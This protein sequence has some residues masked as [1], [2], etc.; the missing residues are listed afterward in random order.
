MANGFVFGKGGTPSGG[1]YS[2]LI[3]TTVLATSYNDPRDIKIT[4]YIPNNIPDMP[5]DGRD[6]KLAYILI[7]PDEIRIQSRYCSIFGWFYS[8]VSETNTPNLRA[9]LTGVADSSQSSPIVTV[10]GEFY[11]K[12][13]SQYIF[14]FKSPI[15]FLELYQFIPPTTVL[16]GWVVA[17]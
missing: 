13:L 7:P 4:I 17:E 11:Q 14:Q 12:T 15:A 6:Y 10:S 8:D 16:C 3:S 5:D 1:E 9:I 2:S